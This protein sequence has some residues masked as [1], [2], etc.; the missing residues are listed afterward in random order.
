MKKIRSIA[1][2]L[3]QFHPIQENNH[4]WGEGFTEWRNVV[5][6]KPKFRNHYQPHIPSN[7]GFYDLRLEESRVLQ[8]KIAKENNIFGFCYYHYWFNGKRLLNIPLDENITLKTPNFPFCLCWANEN[9][10]RNWDGRSGINLMEQ[11]YSNDD[12][13]KHIHW[14]SEIF[15]DSRYI[16]IDGKPLFLIYRSKLFPNIK[17]SINTW[18]EEYKNLG[19]GELYIC[20]VE[21]FANEIGDPIIDGFDAS[22]EFQP[23]WKNLGLPLRRNFFWKILN[24]FSLGS[25]AFS[26]NKIYNY[27][28]V[29]NRMLKRN[30]VNYKRYPCVT[31][32]WDNS[33]RRVSDA[34]IFKDS[35]PDLFEK[36]IRTVVEEFVPYSEN[37]NFLFI[38][39]W[40]E[41]AEG[42]HLEPDLKWG[43]AYLDIVKKN[44]E[45][46]V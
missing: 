43:V 42:N 44:L 33:P 40:N 27:S 2:Y 32:S 19:Y 24:K 20:K 26:E 29:V 18:R 12:D 13:V 45:K 9:W 22:I 34:V 41:W 39:A 17:K 3:P 15:N 4:W 30:N 25:R 28:D 16:K 21:S 1:F 7:L 36:W 37:E 35:T 8:A 23:D 31:P 5:K 46:Y 14:L 6:S 10:T 11:N 38:N